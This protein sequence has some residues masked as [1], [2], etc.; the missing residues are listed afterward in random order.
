MKRSLTDEL[1]A[2]P[3]GLHGE[4]HEFWGLAWPALRWLEREVRPAMRTL[5]TGSGASTLAFA[6]GGADHVAITPDPREEEAVR[7]QADRLDIDHS[8]VQFAIGPS[9]ELL[10]RLEPSPLD[11][12][13]VDGAHGFP[14]P[15]LD[16]W[17]IAPRL[18][19][20]ARMLLDDAYMPPVAALVDALRAQSAW[21][22]AETVGSRTVIV[23]KL[24][25]ELPPFDW[26]GERIGGR[27]S[28]RYLPPAERAVAS[29]RHRVFS[30]ELGLRTLAIARRRSGLRW[31]KRG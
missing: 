20:G 4:G 15:L 25:D 19:V 2:L 8:R 3:P 29:V 17:Y 30:T 9:H 7:E 18:R 26:H 6:A 11:L 22:I 16:W 27:M 28:F 12:V 5:E 10:P 21:E 31:R 24:A 13:L 23:R 1:R 14:Y